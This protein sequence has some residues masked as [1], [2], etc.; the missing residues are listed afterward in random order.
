MEQ[1]GTQGREGY[2]HLGERAEGKAAFDFKKYYLRI[3]N[4]TGSLDF[5]KGPK[6]IKD[7]AKRFDLP[8]VDEVAVMERDPK[9]LKATQWPF[10]VVVDKKPFIVMAE[11]EKELK[12]WI[13]SISATKKQVTEFLD[14]ILPRTAATLNNTQKAQLVNFREKLFSTGLTDEEKQWCDDACL[15]RYLRARVDKFGWNLEKSLLM[16]QD[17]LKWRREFKPEDIKEEDVREL[18]EMGMLYNNG[19]DKQ[20]RPIVMV[21]FNQPMTDFVLYTRYVVFV[22]EKAIASMNPEETEQMLWIL[23]LKGSNRKCFPPK[24]VC[25]EA[26]NI[27]YT[28]YPERLHKLYIVDAPKVFSV[29]WAMLS[30][31]LESDTKAKINFLSGAIGPGQ[32]KTDALLE[33]VDVNVLESDYG[34]NNP[35]KDRGVIKEDEEEPDESELAAQE[36]ST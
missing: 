18:I 31:F 35:S 3:N 20:G 9:K 10:K 23:D 24:A 25:K 1:S 26:L 6:N 15:A 32:K 30:A 33:L 8:A 29:F 13:D 2:V 12:E 34:G 27:F 5:L 19:K 17:T 4:E 14:T 7:V 11:S 28:H 36:A 16:I 22:M 21:K